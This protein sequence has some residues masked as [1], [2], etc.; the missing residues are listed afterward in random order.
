MSTTLNLRQSKV[1][2]PSTVEGLWATL[3][4]IPVI[5]VALGPGRAQT[6]L[7]LHALSQR[8]SGPQ[9]P[10]GRGVVSTMR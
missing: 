6:Q 8:A 9:L 7:R 1:N 4:Y 10:F 2:N 5:P 3:Y